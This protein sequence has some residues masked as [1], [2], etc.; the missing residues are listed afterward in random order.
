MFQE[1]A[2]GPK[3]HEIRSLKGNISLTNRGLAVFRSSP[4]LESVECHCHLVMPA[5]LLLP[6]EKDHREEPTRISIN[7]ITIRALILN[8][9][10]LI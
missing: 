7:F 4:N 8:T 3:H 6:N 5:M 1:I 9:F 10:K 2:L